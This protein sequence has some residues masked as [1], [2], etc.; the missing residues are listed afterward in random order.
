M[1]Y[2]GSLEN[3]Y[4]RWDFWVHFP[5]TRLIQLDVTSRLVA[6]CAGSMMNEHDDWRGQ[7]YEQR[8]GADDV[9]A[10]VQQAWP[11]RRLGR[12]RPFDLSRRAVPSRARAA[13]TRAH[14]ATAATCPASGKRS[15]A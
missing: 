5:V 7:R 9:C 12:A 15:D 11:A 1:A 2:R 10:A 13:G 4:A 8:R 3:G 6:G 14:P